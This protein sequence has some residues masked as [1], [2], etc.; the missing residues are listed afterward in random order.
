VFSWPVYRPI[1]VNPYATVVPPVVQQPIQPQF[2]L[3][4]LGFSS[5]HIDGLG[6]QVVS[7]SWT[8]PAAR[9][10][11]QPGDIVLSMNGYVL[12]YRGAWHDA[13]YQAVTNGGYIQLAVRDARSGQIVYRETNLGSNG[14]GNVQPG[15]E[16]QYRIARP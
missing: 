12:N 16:L 7:V 9:L 5:Q 2:Q 3:P 8:S 6:E 14:G 10:G 11:L 1:V 13:L 15:I 4:K